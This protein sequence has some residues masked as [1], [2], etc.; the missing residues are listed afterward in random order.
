MVRSTKPGLAAVEASLAT[1]PAPAK[2]STAPTAEQAKMQVERVRQARMRYRLRHQLA[3]SKVVTAVWTAGWLAQAAA[4]VTGDAAGTALATAGITGAAAVVVALVLGRRRT[5]RVRLWLYACL[6]AAVTW[7]SLATGVG[8]TWSTTAALAAM[9]Y[10][11]AIPWWR[12]HRIPNPPAPSAVP[13]ALGLVETTTAALWSVNIAGKGGALADSYLTDAQISERKERYTVQLKAGKQSIATALAAL[14]LIAS[15]LH[16]APE[17]LVVER[18][19]SGDASRVALTVVRQSPIKVSQPYTAPQ[20]HYD[21]SSRIGWVGLGPYADGDGLAPWKVFSKN[22]IWGGVIIGGTGSGK[23]RLLEGLVASMRASGV[24]NCF[25]ADPQGGTSS[26]ALAGTADWSARGVDQIMAWLRA[27]DRLIYWR[28]IENSAKGRSG[29]TPSTARPGIVAILDECQMVL[30]DAVYGGEA[31]A[32]CERIARVGRKLGIALI[33]A[34]QEGDLPTFGGNAALRSNVREGNTVV[35]RTSNRMT[36]TVL[37]LDFDPLLLPKLGGY[38]YTVAAPGSKDRTAPF[39]GFY[40][41]E[42]DDDELDAVHAGAAPREGTSHWWLDRIRDAPL[43]GDLV[44]L[45][46]LGQPYVERHATVEAARAA[47]TELLEQL[48]AGHIDP[49]DAL[50]RDA[51]AAEKAKAAAASTAAEAAGYGQVVTFPGALNLDVPAPAAPQAATGAGLPG[52]TAGQRDV[53]QAIAA[54]HA[55][56]SAIETATGLSDSGVRKILTQLIGSGAVVKAARGTYAICAGGAGDARDIAVDQLLQDAAELVVT[57][58]F[59]SAAMLARKLRVNHEQA[60]WLIERLEDVGVIAAD[61]TSGE[62]EVLVDADQLHEVLAGFAA[63]DD[64][65]A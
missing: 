11:L 36:A 25:Y 43:D 59:A 27:L 48:I 54:G 28:G 18:H 1:L 34:S 5:R 16:V 51:A 42:L 56:P 23:S 37:S 55:S 10:G 6:G 30:G 3:P 9:G 62:L 40:L 35:L 53:Y 21:R 44:A 52:M 29:F 4:W 19:E 22:S 24:I 13:D 45:R 17:D 47:Q 15:G 14:T 63:P 65:A 12:Q 26:D 58:Q 46:A 33:L 32:I 41:D 20:W 50:R 31:T 57:A 64:V 8:V 7:L 2:S 39:R 49:A 61:D 38:G 60:T